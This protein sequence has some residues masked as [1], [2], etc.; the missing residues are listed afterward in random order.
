MSEARHLAGT[1]QTDRPTYS[2]EEAAAV[3]E[4]DTYQNEQIV[5]PGDAE[6]AAD[7]YGD[8]DDESWA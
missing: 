4:D 5:D 6:A 3:G 2:P 1:D 7:G 8:G